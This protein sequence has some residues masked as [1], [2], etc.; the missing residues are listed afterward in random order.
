MEA[1]RELKN[2][3]EYWWEAKE[4]RN[5]TSLSFITLFALDTF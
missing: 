5:D 4:K 2:T 3:T 1:Q